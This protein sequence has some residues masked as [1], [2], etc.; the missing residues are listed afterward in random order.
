M[1]LLTVILCTML[2]IAGVRADEQPRPPTA[3]AAT[4]V[5]EIPGGGFEANTEGWHF[6][7][8]RGDCCITDAHAFEGKHALRI[9]DDHRP[10]GS[11]KVESPKVPCKGPG[12]VEL[13]GK[14]Q[15]FS[16][17]HLG[18]TIREYDAEGTLLPTYKNNHGE[19]G[20][21]DGKWHDILRQ[22]ILDERT[23]ALQLFFL[24][25]P[26]KDERIELYVDDLRFVRPSMRIPPWQSQ[27]KI[28]PHEKG[29]LTAA[30]VVGPDGIVYP[31]WE[32]VGVQGGI[33]DV[34]VIA[35]LSDRGVVQESE[36]SAVLANACEIA[37]A[38][39]GGAVLIPEGTYFLDRPVTIRSGGVVIR[40]A[41]RDRT[42]LIFRGGAG[43]PGTDVGFYWP[44]EGDVVGPDSEVQ[45]HALHKKLKS[46]VLFRDGREVK[47]QVGDGAWTYA[48]AVSGEDLLNAGGP[49]SAVLRAEAE[50]VD[51]RKVAAQRRVTVSSEPQATK[52]RPHT[53]AALYFRGAGLEDK[54]HFL[55]ADANRGDTVLVFKDAG[56]LKPGDKLD[57]HAPLTDRFCERT[58][59]RAP[60][61]WIRVAYIEILAIDGNRAT[62]N[63]PLRI[64]FPAE[65][66]TYARR[67]NPIENSGI[68]DL[69]IE[70]VNRLPI[71]SVQFEWAWNCWARNVTVRKTG[72]N[73]AYAEH[74][75]WI[76]IRDCELDGSWNNDGGQAYAGFTRSADCLME[77]C[78]VRKYRHGPVVQYG[79][80]GNVFRNSTFDGSDLQ[81]HA[82]WS[83]EN[84]FENCV[85][86]SYRGHGSYG[87]GAYATG[88]NDQTHGPNGPRNVVYNCD[89]TSDRGGVML[90]GV[91]E[92]WLFLHNRFVVK[93]GAGFV[94][95]GGSFDHILRNN[96][97]VLR[98]DESPMLELRT[99][100][101][102]GIELI[103]NRLYGGSGKVY[104]SGPALAADTGN[105]VLPASETGPS[106]PTANPRSIYEWQQM[107]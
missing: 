51:G 83:T 63:Q 11:A 23:V 1:G 87:Y 101:C 100:D 85:V 67:L 98:D 55:A 36:I 89:I 86:R 80:M 38:N 44:A 96:T 29:R 13:H 82:G 45:V 19:L 97:F 37:A 65:D 105:Q 47:R 59:N 70:H 28:R 66:G 20:G 92:H 77:D 61:G 78:V 43:A 56:D 50:Y 6:P 33:P 41:G 69:T 93:K 106:R 53:E 75:K 60:R 76:E 95:L 21:T 74:S 58:R 57:L 49:G 9:V 30:D 62:I 34:P 15:S 5:I 31:N 46:L 81:W 25:Y 102:V 42:R 26:Q 27:Y 64:D 4:T 99:P 103:G 48:L 71:D 14:F 24:G 2:S 22:V 72:R 17:R 107:Q 16:G 88:S 18:L 35:R 52:H 7:E 32:Q 84:L 12:V 10:T 73:G 39:G 91:N 104:G 3:T 79:A 40:G 94:G 54:E 90:H 8:G 68:E